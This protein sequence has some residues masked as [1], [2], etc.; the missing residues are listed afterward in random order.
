MYAGDLAISKSHRKAI[1]II[2]DTRVGKST[3]FNYIMGIPLIGKE[4]P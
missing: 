3:L 1:L 2:G 4:D